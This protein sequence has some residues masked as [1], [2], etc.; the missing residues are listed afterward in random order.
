M[1]CEVEGIKT[2][3]K[4]RTVVIYSTPTCPYCRQAKQYLN[5]RGIAYT[6]YNVAEDRKA[7]REMIEKSKQMG[8]PIIIV[9]DKDIVVGFDRDKLEK[10]LA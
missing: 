6:D 5:E 1:F 7:A 2:V 8:V 9:D 10:L 3:E 4:R